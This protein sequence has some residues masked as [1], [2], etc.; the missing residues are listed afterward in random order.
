MRITITCPDSMA[1][2]FN[3]YKHRF[4][5]LRVCQ[6]AIAA[7]IRAIQERETYLGVPQAMTAD[8]KRSFWVDVWGS[9]E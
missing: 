4:N 7:E 6:R 1:D 3:R 5:V 8:E 9:I 2:D